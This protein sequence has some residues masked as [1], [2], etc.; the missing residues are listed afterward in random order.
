MAIVAREKP[1]RKADAALQVDSNGEEAG[2]IPQQ[3]LE[4]MPKYPTPKRSRQ[5]KSARVLPTKAIDVILCDT[6]D[7]IRKGALRKNVGEQI[8]KGVG[9]SGTNADK[10]E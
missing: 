2:S 4:L 9:K 7:G 5:G 6:R 10:A 1:T 8:A 3:I